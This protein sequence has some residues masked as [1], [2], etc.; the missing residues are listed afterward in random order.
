MTESGESARVR[1]HQHTLRS[2]YNIQKESTLHLVLRLRGGTGAC[3]NWEFCPHFQSRSSVIR[4]IFHSKTCPSASVWHLVLG[5]CCWFFSFMIVLTSFVGNA[6]NDWGACGGK[7]K[8]KKQYRLQEMFYHMCQIYVFKAVWFDLSEVMSVLE[9][10]WPLF[11][12]RGLVSWYFGK[13]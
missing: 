7:Q 1:H 11:S 8:G 13:A 12:F 3:W 2:D 10:P 4:F 5:G 9:A 6:M